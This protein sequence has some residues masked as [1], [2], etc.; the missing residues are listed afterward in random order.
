MLRLIV[1]ILAVLAAAPE[2]ASALTIGVQDQGA[3][4]TALTQLAGDLGTRTV[5]VV[6]SPQNPET[7]LVQR[8]HA[9][10]L[11]VQAAITVK[12]QTTVADI[13]RT[14][15]AWHGAV[16]TVSVG[17]EPDLNGIGAGAYA[18]LWASSARMIRREFPG[19]RVGLG[20][21]SPAKGEY[22]V[23]VARRLKGARPS[24]VAWHPYQF[25][26]DPMAAPTEKSGVGSWVGLGNLPAWTRKVARAGV[27]APAWCTE[28]SYLVDG[29]YR[30]TMTR[31]TTLWPR[32]IIRAQRVCGELILYG[33]GV[34]PAGSWGS[35]ALLD[36]HGLRTPA[37]VAIAKALGR[38]LRA[39]HPVAPTGLLPDGSGPDRVPPLP[40]LLE[41]TDTA[42]GASSDQ[43]TGGDDDAT[44]DPGDDPDV[45]DV[46][47]NPSAP[48]ICEVDDI[49][50][51]DWDANGCSAYYPDDQDAG[52]LEDPGDIPEDDGSDDGAE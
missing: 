49:T 19:V 22:A 48:A 36:A 6:A 35:A 46:D 1:I 33:F 2:A 7:A 29:R 27:K 50:D 28:F 24:F 44:E 30:I 15:R 18:R 16:R 14:M 12:R 34:V 45:S 21:F 38:T 52:P 20:E 3:D 13:R 40:A 47:P 4:P 17:N 9:H 43:P 11:T 42:T 26:S 8:Y 37:F 5:R 25:F 41:R 32:A 39:E 23:Q 10:G 51:A 31:A